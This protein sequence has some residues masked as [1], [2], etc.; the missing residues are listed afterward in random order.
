M[1]AEEVY[2]AARNDI[3]RIANRMAK[4]RPDIAEEYESIASLAF[5]K[6]LATHRSD[7]GSLQRWITLCIQNEIG[8]ARIKE[9]RR[10]HYEN[11]AGHATERSRRDRTQDEAVGPRALKFVA[12][13][14]DDARE[15]ATAV[16]AEASG[17]IRYALTRAKEYLFSTM[18]R[19]RFVT[20]FHEIKRSL[21]LEGS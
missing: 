17:D 10:K 5:M 14:S 6:A 15:V 19:A 21:D 9:A 16:I 20:A 13:M 8:H 7:K 18:G 3:L 12:L 2:V 4:G 1:N 11:E